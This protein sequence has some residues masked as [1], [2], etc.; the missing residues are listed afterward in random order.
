MMCLASLASFFRKQFPSPP[1]AGYVLVGLA[2]ALLSAGPT[3]QASQTNTP[4]ALS[5]DAHKTTS[6]TKL[7]YGTVLYEFYRGDFFAALVNHEYISAHQNI[8]A[9]SNDGQILKGG[10]TLSYGMPIYSEALFSGLLNSSESEK[11]R[12]AAWYYLSKLYYTK[13][14]LERARVNLQRIQGELPND[15]HIDYHYLA[16]LLSSD[17]Q[18]SL[19]SWN[20]IEKIK[21]DLPEYPYFLFN[22]AVTQL[23]N[24]QPLEAIRNLEEVVGYAYL[25]EEYEVLA[26]RARHGLALIST[27][28]GRLLEAWQ[29]LSTVRTT[30][31]Y[32][33]RALL[34]YAWAAIK[35]K[36]YT[37][38]VPALEIL[39]SRSIAIPEVQEAKV[40]L[41][42]LYEQQGL[43][44]KA[45][46][47]NI[48]AEKA[49]TKGLEQLQQARAL[50][51]SQEVPR[52]FVTNLETL[53][54]QTDWYSKN[55]EVDYD[56]LTPFLIDLLASNHFVE[57]LK[58]L[59]DL[60]SM[61]DNLNYW[62]AQTEQHEIILLEGSQKSFDDQAEKTLQE[63]QRLTNE[64]TAQRSELRLVALTLEPEERDRF[65]ALLDSVEGEIARLNTKMNVLQAVQDPYIQ[66]PEYAGFMAEKHQQIDN[67]LIVTRTY[68][69]EL[70]K[71]MRKLV[72]L[73]L[74]K[75]ESRMSYY[76]AQSKLAKARLYDL[77]LTTLGK[78]KQRAE[79]AES[80]EQPNNDE[81]RQ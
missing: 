26:D 19:E 75:H 50:I 25:G 35:L 14:D 2:G 68:I 72:R 79:E 55:P 44:R 18:H 22:R 45:L 78:A 30:G 37:T 62:L 7:E 40:L 52:E 6:R 54:R 70:E 81:G 34:S 77:T 17:G 60:Y 12:N 47:Q 63:S 41:A 56:L 24:E 57:T 33:N 48:I 27:R 80:S 20:A 29:Y 71:V 42:Y 49:F 46:K 5:L 53:V 51:A 39:D 61:E 8:R 23:R 16:T 11:T 38:A 74:D 4:S 59:A 21:E 69:L 3:A 31:L 64:L 32:S 1:A 15:I 67:K 28:E 73:E 10:M 9:L 43:V 65:N 13:F 58:E 66:P 76:A 36:Q